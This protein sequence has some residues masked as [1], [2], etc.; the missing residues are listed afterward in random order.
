[1]IKNCHRDGYDDV[2]KKLS[3]LREAMLGED[4]QP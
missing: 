2:A 4:E 3:E 1:M